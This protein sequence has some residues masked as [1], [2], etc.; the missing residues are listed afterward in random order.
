[1]DNSDKIKAHKEL[2]KVVKKHG[3]EFKRSG[4]ANVYS[5]KCEI[6]RL[7]KEEEFGIPLI[8]AGDGHFSVVGAYNVW[9]RVL[10][11]SDENERSISWSDDDRQP[12]NEWLYVVSFGSGPYIF[13]GDYPQETFKSFFLELKEFGAKYCDT[14]NSC[15]YFT[16]DKAKAVHGAFWEIFNRHKAMVEGELNKKRKEDLLKE[17]KKL[18]E[19]MEC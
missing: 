19:E 1:M 7:E 18:L 9:S 10:Y 8:R 11:F 3:D 4:V 15:L 6:E 14:A 13:G 12:E 5:I 16:P 17:L 2:L